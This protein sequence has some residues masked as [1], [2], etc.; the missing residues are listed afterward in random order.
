MS[1]PGFIHLRVRSA[2]SLLEGAIHI[3]DLVKWCKKHAMPAIAVTDSGNL[4][5]SLEFSMAAMDAGI[6]PIHGCV[7]YIQPLQTHDGR[8]NAAQAQKP[9]QLLAIAQNDAGWR[10]LLALVS[11]SHLE[12][13]GGIA[14]LLTLADLQQ[15]SEGLIILTGG[16]NGAIGKA[17]L[18]GRNAAAEAYLELLKP[19]F[20][21]RLYVE[22]ARHGLAEEAAIEAKLID[23]AYAH[24]LPLVATNDAH[25][26]D[27]DMFEAHDAFLCI[28]E[29]SYTVETNRRKLTSEHRLKSAQEMMALYADIPEA[30]EN[31]IAIARRC[32]Y[33]ASPKSPILPRFTSTETGEDELLREQAKQG[34]AER[35]ERYVFSA[36][37]SDEEKQAK[38]KPYWDGLQFELDTIIAMKFPGYFLIVSDFIKWSKAQGIPVGPGRGSGAG[39]VVA[40][41]LSITDLDP[42]RYGLLF[43][44]FL[45]PQRVSMPDFDVDFCQE[46]REEVIQYVQHKYG[47]D[48][49][50]QIIT[51]G[52]LQARA[53]LRDVGRVLQM[54][55]PQVDKIC[56][57]IPNNPAAPVT[58]AE[59]I[60]MEP[61]LKAAIKD[62]EQVAH[63]VDLSLKLEGL[64]RHASTHAAGVVIGDRPLQELV[65]MYRDPKSQM[66][67]VQYSMKY[68][69]SAGLVKF[70]FLG[71]K[72]LTVLARAVA[73]ILPQG[74]EIDL[75]AL[76]EGDKK[77]YEMLSRGDTVGVFQLESAGMRDT[78][79][80][81]KPD[82]LE[83]IIALVS[84][85][86]PGPM[87]N[88]PAY[89]DRKHGN[90][91]P[92]YLH[93]ML[94]TVLKETF[95][96]IIYQEQVMQ[97]AQLLAG[98]SLGEADLLRRAMG[99]KIRSEMEA[100]RDI[101]VQ[102]AVGRGVEK[103][104]A[105]SIFDLIAK[106]A[107]YGF[108]KSHAA[109][110]ALIAYQT[111]YLKANYPVEFIAASM[112]CDMHNTD[113]LGVFREE[114]MRF[115]ISLLPPDINKSEVLFSVEDGKIRY[116]LAAVRNVGAQAM[117]ALVEERN[118][119]G[120]Y[121]DIFDCMA[122]VPTEM[123]NRRA[124]EHL[125]KAGAF[126]ALHPNRQ[127]LFSGIDMLLA[128]GQSLQR[129]QDSQQ[130]SLFASVGEP[131]IEA[132]RLPAANDWTS[133]ERLEHEFSAIGFYLSSH[134][135]AGYRTALQQLQVVPSSAFADK[136]DGQYRS[137]KVAGIVTGRKFKISDKGRF[138]FVQLSD[139][140]GVFEVSIFNE[141]L[142]TQ[143]RDNLENGKILLIHADGKNEESGMRLIAQQITLFDEAWL[144]QQKIKGAGVLKIVVNQP[145]ALGAIRDLLGL[146]NGQGARI[147]L[148]ATLEQGQA[149]IELP[150]K[151]L[152]SPTIIEKIRIVS[153]VVSAEELAA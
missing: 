144:K 31:T 52:K 41:A 110:Y 55:Y 117:Q 140:G 134:P 24:N 9:D 146:P 93:P 87:D 143:H 98:Y 135:L 4:F 37:M 27:A 14:P 151:Y 71:L 107:E 3:K 75:L 126:D 53:V 49:V 88:I 70:D 2:Y 80:K 57:L 142:L 46:R 131:V 141:L 65:P 10:N 44:R 118:T 128:Y 78:L 86:R 136:L 51:F 62:D 30:L 42:L 127:Q 79:K 106:F 103:R 138:A 90:E 130:E 35:L 59:A 102:R 36:G 25:F 121:K 83:D 38:A 149:D 26:I 85:Y 16:I 13:A 119:H 125:I 104:Q 145:T 11:K 152:V 18:A 74:I 21:G 19:H 92:E 153:G 129:Q 132:P 47:A 101:F 33:A 100:Q 50:A 105:A 91:T 1:A 69:E 66:P 8:Q 20:T 29:G 34:L 114:A 76:P 17:L 67:V 60:D 133:L 58:L 95:G 22:L 32:S 139:M 113:K 40:W 73:L 7:L 28:A 61:T 23:M 124:I 15:H 123:L 94:E 115:G 122:R 43:E 97:I 5:G 48:R 96:V 147:M 111:A 63:L 54:P 72:T 6:Q 84:L 77:T 39:S 56:K 81:L 12:P 45:N 99:K 109:A 108:N 68:A 150:G 120:E 137:I 116:A 89:I 82:C 112:T 148:T 64:N